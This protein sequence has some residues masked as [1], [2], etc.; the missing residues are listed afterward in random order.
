MRPLLSRRL[1]R[2]THFVPNPLADQTKTQLVFLHTIKTH[3]R[4]RQYYNIHNIPLRTRALCI[5]R[6]HCT[7]MQVDAVILCPGTLSFIILFL[8]SFF[9]QWNCK[10]RRVRSGVRDASSS[11]SVSSSIR[12]YC[13]TAIYCCCYHDYKYYTTD[14]YI[15]MY[16][17]R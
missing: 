9:R 16:D 11:S 2:S 17:M 15:I 1:Y 13:Y 7:H 10:Q 8:L 3:A 6:V 14:V 4:T 5:Y 12:L